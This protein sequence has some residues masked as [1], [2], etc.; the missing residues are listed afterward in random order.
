MK[1]T[2][3]AYLPD[4]EILVIRSIVGREEAENMADVLVKVTTGA[5]RKRVMRATGASNTLSSGM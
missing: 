5:G 4:G 1:Y 2:L 3:T